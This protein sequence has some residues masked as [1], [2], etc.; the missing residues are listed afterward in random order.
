MFYVWGEVQVGD[1]ACGIG[2]GMLTLARCQG[3]CDVEA[4]G[5]VVVQQSLPKCWCAPCTGLPVVN[6]SQV[7][8]VYRHNANGGKPARMSVHES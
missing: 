6:A 3:M 7:N 4:Y 8:V 5:A 2:A 1:A